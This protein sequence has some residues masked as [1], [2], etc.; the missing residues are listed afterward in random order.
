[1][2]SEALRAQ[3]LGWSLAGKESGTHEVTFAGA[4]R[5]AFAAFTARLSTL[6]G[7]AHDGKS[8]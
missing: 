2:S 8:A 3:L 6:T 1:M 7:A 4:A 5:A